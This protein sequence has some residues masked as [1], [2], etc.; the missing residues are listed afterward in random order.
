MLIYDIFLILRYRALICSLATAASVAVAQ[1]KYHP[2]TMHMSNVFA[3][4]CLWRNGIDI[5]FG[6]SRSQVWTGPEKAV[7]FLKPLFECVT[8]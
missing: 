2:N 8:P 5:S 1:R 6:T 4:V 7:P 3:S